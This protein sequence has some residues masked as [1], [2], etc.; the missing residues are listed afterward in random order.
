M[1]AEHRGEF[2][3]L[4]SFRVELGILNVK[5]LFT[6]IYPNLTWPLVYSLLTALV[7]LPI[8]IFP[9]QRHVLIVVFTVQDLV[10]SA[11]QCRRRAFNYS[12]LLEFVMF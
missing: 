9:R 6:H 7:A 2:A 12:A 1:S 10:N 4:S 3:E 8:I 5:F 11:I